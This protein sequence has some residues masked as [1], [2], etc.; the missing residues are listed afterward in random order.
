MTTERQ[1]LYYCDYCRTF[2]VRYT[3]GSWEQAMERPV[4]SGEAVA[5]KLSGG[6]SGQ[7]PCNACRERFREEEEGVYERS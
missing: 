7:S 6:K 2:Y 3:T 1:I 4:S 5:M